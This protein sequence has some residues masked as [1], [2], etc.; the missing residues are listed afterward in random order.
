MLAELSATCPGCGEAMYRR[1]RGEWTLACRILRFAD[2]GAVTAKC[3]RCGGDAPVTFLRV[4]P[5]GADPKRTRVLV[6]R[7]ALDNP[8]D[9]G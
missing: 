9:S 4:E 6:Q 3:D 7:R 2:D 1:R 8:R 5:S